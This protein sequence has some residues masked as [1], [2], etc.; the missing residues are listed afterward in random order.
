MNAVWM[1]LLF[2]KLKDGGKCLIRNQTFLPFSEA[3]AGFVG[4]SENSYFLL[5]FSAH[6]FILLF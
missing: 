2:A 5:H 1:D 3:V 4:R 6:R